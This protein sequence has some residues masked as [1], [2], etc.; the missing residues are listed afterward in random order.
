M[1]TIPVQSKPVPVTLIAIL[2]IAVILIGFF[3]SFGVS[4]FK[5]KLASTSSGDTTTKKFDIHSF[6]KEEYKQFMDDATIKTKEEGLETCKK[7]GTTGCY[8]LIAVSF[9][10]IGLCKQSPNQKECEAQVDEAKKEFGD[11]D[12]GDSE[13]PTGKLEEDT[14]CVAGPALQAYQ[15]KMRVSGKESITLDGKTY[16]TCCLEAIPDSPEEAITKSCG[17]LTNP[18]NM[19]VY[20]KV[21]NTY[22]MDYATLTIGDTFCNYEFDS[23][24]KL[25]E[26]TCN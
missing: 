25:E 10:D 15:G 7:N 22:V 23:S 4:F 13:P 14:E 16:Q 3:A 2:G 9:N 26:K 12:G 6:G 19:F 8:A 21:N 17:E 11:M 24:G 1:K 20:N 18:E 5:T